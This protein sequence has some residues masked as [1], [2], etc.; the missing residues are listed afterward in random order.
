MN[1]YI[2]NLSSNVSEQDLRDLFSGYGNIIRTK[3][4]RDPYTGV[5]KGFG[6]VEMPGESEA[7]KAIKELNTKD[8]KG[9]KITVSEAHAKTDS[10]TPNAG[11]KNLYTSRVGRW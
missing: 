5:S 8:I 7:T 1:I 10:R 9:K 2:G 6:F 11:R 3:I 4:V